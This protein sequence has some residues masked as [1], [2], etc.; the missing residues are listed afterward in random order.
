MNSRNNLFF[1]VV[2]IL[3]LFGLSSVIA[4]EVSPRSTVEILIKSISSLE[5]GI[6]LSPEEIKKNDLLSYNA[7]D[8]LN[9][10]EICRK[11]LG[12]YWV[13]RSLTEQKVFVD[14]LS[15]MFIKE[16]FPNSGKFFSTLKLIYGQTSINK[17]KANVPLSVVH[18][19]EGEINIVFHLY[20]YS[21]QWQVVDVA[22]DGISMRNNLRSK[23]YK[24]IS[25]N[26][27]QELVRRLEQKLTEIKN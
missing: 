2:F 17:S 20:K 15:L 14:L 5:T 4:E 16:A 23:L 10:K 11:A 18:D 8:L 7:L 26:N 19:K 22:L 25:K 9:I 21:N 12:K 13:K 24:I 1:L 6:Q 27:Y 3:S